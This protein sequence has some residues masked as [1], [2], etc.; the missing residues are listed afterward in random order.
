MAKE[1]PVDELLRT[2]PVGLDSYTIKM[3]L[4]EAYET[5]YGIYNHDAPDPN[6]P[7]ALIAMHPKEDTRERSPLYETIERYR[8]FDVYKYYGLNLV[9]FLSL[10]RDVVTEIFRQLTASASKESSRMANA[11]KELEEK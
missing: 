6:R 4:M 11:L 10:P 2:M 7:L 3:L 1:G 5:K 9:E 8:I